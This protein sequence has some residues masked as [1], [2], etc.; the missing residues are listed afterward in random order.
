MTSI[1]GSIIFCITKMKRSTSAV[2]TVYGIIE[3]FG[4][5]KFSTSQLAPLNHQERLLKR[6]VIDK[7]SMVS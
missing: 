4:N 6:G 5:E 1:G 7:Q 2:S 3:Y